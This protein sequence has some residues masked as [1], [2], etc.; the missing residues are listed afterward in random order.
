MIRLLV[1]DRVLQLSVVVYAL[2]LGFVAAAR[3]APDSVDPVLFGMTVVALLW[4][5]SRVHRRERKF[6]DML[7]LAWSCWL[8]VEGLFFL[9]WSAPLLSASFTTDALYILFYLIFALAVDLRPDVEAALSL[10]GVRRRLESVAG[11][12][13]VFG[14][15]I[16]F[17]IVV[18]PEPLGISLSFVSRDRGFTP[19]LLVRLTL[20]LLLLGRLVHTASGSRARWR[21]LYGLLAAGMACFA[22]KDALAV[23]Q[24]EG[25]FSVTQ[26]GFAYA[27]FLSLPGFFVILAAR[28]RHV[29]SPDVSDHTVMID[30]PR[31]DEVIRTSPPVIYVVVVPALHFLLYP[32]GLLEPASRAPREVY[33][34]LYVLVLGI[35]AWSHQ[36]LVAKDSRRAARALRRVE[37]RLFRSQ[38]LESVGRLAGGIA[39]DFNNY[40]TVIRGYTE[41]LRERLQGPEAQSEIGYIDDAARNATHLTRQL[42][43]YGRRQVLRPEA[44]DLNEVVLETGKLLK[45]LL[46]E[47][48]TLEVDLDPHVG[49]ARADLGQTEQVIMNLALNGRDA[50]PEG[51]VLSVR[52]H[53]VVLSVSEA[54]G[55]EVQPGSYVGLAIADTGTGMTEEVQA[56]AQ[57]PFFTTKE[58]GRGTGLGLSTVHGIVAQSGGAISLESVVGEGTTVRVLLP[59]AEGLPQREPVS[60]SRPEPAREKTTLLVVEDD[61]RVR[62]LVVRALT[63]NG[64]SVQEASD[65]REALDRFSE[66][67]PIDMLVT[68]VMMPGMDGIQLAEDLVSRCPGL[69]VL[70]ISGYPANTLRE[71]HAVLLRSM[72][73][74]EKPFTPAALIAKVNEVLAARQDSSVPVHDLVAEQGP[75]GQ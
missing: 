22:L 3:I 57:E 37:E 75:A 11:L 41:L 20:D 13:A 73:L 42:L 60:E 33:A 31:V 4:G 15:L 49:L 1:T 24:S 5:R 35:M 6:W 10:K 50:M 27:A 36:R 69:R 16:Y 53:R 71:R 47:D 63:G 43:A 58:Q 72:Q 64:F 17:A 55:F 28:Y 45:S 21:R 19:L 61:E 38:R 51:G 48:V 30:D 74:L 8:L 14:V 52:T 44:L 2:A 18:I 54:V 56:H 67:P 65:G 25:L 7:A 23:L 62:S 40:L 66:Y 32:L 34:L 70:F 68:D 29:S 9:D 12:T 39:H 26:L 46:G 59:V